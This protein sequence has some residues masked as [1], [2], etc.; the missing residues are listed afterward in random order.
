MGGA[1]GRTG[2]DG[3]AEC[4]DGA[5]PWAFL[6]P[7]EEVTDP[8]STPRTGTLPFDDKEIS[9]DK[10]DELP[11]ISRSKSSLCNFSSTVNSVI[12]GAWDLSISP[13]Q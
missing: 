13:M 4:D 5:P 1:E 8:V 6:P 11:P 12:S 10:S 2:A 7:L 9:A 3:R